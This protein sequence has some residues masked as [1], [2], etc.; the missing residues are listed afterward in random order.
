MA[1]GKAKPKLTD[2]EKL[3]L[4]EQQALAAQEEKARRAELALKFLKA[5]LTLLPV[6]P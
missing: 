4:K 6:T 5:R 2:E 1:K 3:L